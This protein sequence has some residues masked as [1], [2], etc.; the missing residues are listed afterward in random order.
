MPDDKIEFPKEPWPIDW[1]KCIANRQDEIDGASSGLREGDEMW[2]VAR[3]IGPIYINRNH[4][5]GEHLEGERHEITLAAAAPLLLHVIE[6]LL[7]RKDDI[8]HNTYAIG[9]EIQA[10]EDAVKIAKMGVPE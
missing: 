9:P 1:Y 3:S 7:K 5:S 6:E 10:L 8:L 2:R 4:W